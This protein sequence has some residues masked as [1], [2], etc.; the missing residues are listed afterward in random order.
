MKNLSKVYLKA[1]HGGVELSDGATVIRGV[2]VCTAGEAKGHGVQLDRSFIQECY[3]Q[4]STMKLGLKARFGHPSMCNEALGTYVGRFRDFT[5]VDDGQRLLADFYLAESA[6]KAPGGDLHSY[7]AEYAKE[8]PDS[9]GTSIVF[10][11][12]DSYTINED[13]EKDFESEAGDREVF[14]SCKKLFACDF[15]DEPAANPGGLFSAYHSSTVAG[16]VGQFFDNEPEVLE[17]LLA[18]PEIVEIISLHGDKVEVFLNKIKELNMD[19]EEEFSEEIVQE[20][21]ELSEIEEAVEVEVEEDEDVECEEEVEEA[22]FSLSDYRSLCDEFG[23]VIADQVVDEDGDYEFAQGLH[24]AALESQIEELEKALGDAKE[25]SVDDGA[26]G[27]AFTEGSKVE[28][29]SLTS[30]IKV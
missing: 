17:A 3:S 22:E 16:Q 20:D 29:R 27:V 24:I 13:G 18:N 30:N 15:V 9:F 5:V 1:S 26:D 4:A 10:Q 28:K 11:M 12:G 2:S 7:I 19:Q 8:D 6:R 23:R 21:V 25:L 14:A